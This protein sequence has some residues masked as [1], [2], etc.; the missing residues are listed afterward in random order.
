MNHLTVE[1]LNIKN[2]NAALSLINDAY[3]N[4][5]GFERLTATDL[6]ALE[7]IGLLGAWCCGR[8][9]GQFSHT[10]LWWRRERDR[11]VGWVYPTSFEANVAAFPRCRHVS[12]TSKIKARSGLA[13]LTG[14]MPLIVRC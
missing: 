1:E 13:W 4:V 6:D 10:V 12:T 7:T 2:R 11:S 8:Q 14:W 9:A 5:H 3:D